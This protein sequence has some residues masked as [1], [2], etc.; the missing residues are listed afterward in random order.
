MAKPRLLDL[1][2]GAGGAGMGYHR[3]GFEV[4]GVDNRP[5]PRYPFEFHKADALEYV[6]EHGHEFDVIHAS[7]PCQAYSESTPPEFRALH[8]DLIKPTQKALRE[9][10]KP[11]VIENVE[12]ARAHLVNPLMLCGSM[13]GLKIWRHRYFE[14][15]PIWL[16][17]PMSC[18]H[19]F[20][21][22]LISGQGSTPKRNGK[23]YKSPIAEKREAIKIDWMTV[24]EITEAIPPAYT[25]FI[26]RQL[27]QALEVQS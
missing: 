12:M 17:S 18:R 19:D 27:L 15:C 16:M 14:I 10:G 4:V 7:P 9:T 26:G 8:P 2:C 20:D 6:A 5:M 23:R 3:A 21:P 25:E 13:F 1:F 11:Y 22:I 24:Y